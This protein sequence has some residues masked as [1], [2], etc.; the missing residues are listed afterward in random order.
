MDS[1][2]PSTV[3]SASQP[4]ESSSTAL[5][6]P[7]HSL[8]R[9]RPQEPT[10]L[11]EDTYVRAVS[12]IIE[13]DFFP[14]LQKMKVQNEYLN[15]LQGGE[16]AKAR[17]LGG[18]LQRMATE[19]PG[20]TPSGQTPRFGGNATPMPFDT[21]LSVSST[22]RSDVTHASSISA[23][24]AS[25]PNTKL[26]LDAFQTNYTSEDNA[27]FAG[28]IHKTNEEKKQRYAWVF[29]K[30][31]GKLLL[32]DEK[33]ET[34]CI[35]GMNKTIEGWKYKAKNSLMYYPEGAPETL[36]EQAAARGAPKAVSHASTRFTP[37][38]STE[39]LLK[40][41]EATAEQMRTQDVWREMAKATPALFPGMQH[42]SQ[43][44]VDGFAFVPSTPVLNPGSDVDPSD[45]MT[46]GVI[47]GTPLL[48]DS[49][50]DHS[51]ARSFTIPDTPKREQ[52]SHRLSEK[53][54]K[55]LRTRGSATTP[56]RNHG[57]KTPAPRDRSSI[58]ASPAF[59]RAASPF[60][61]SSALS[62]AAQHLLKQGKQT[63]FGISPLKGGDSQLRASY[64]MTPTKSS[65]LRTPSTGMRTPTQFT[66]DARRSTTKFIPELRIP[67]GGKPA[68]AT[69]DCSAATGSS[70]T[71]NL[72]QL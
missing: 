40:T 69:V 6:A 2:E 42:E 54:S 56:S 20:A 71:D 37:T 53:A 18:E 65:R 44:G 27:S 41:A 49:G 48:M 60:L 68:P 5:T 72:L 57:F 55:S 34:K 29:D 63:A 21:P 32:E 26:S 39:Q 19:N 14:N 50:A 43:P 52:L 70:I 66:P 10:V 12:A 13:R 30:E 3:A 15:A 51:G 28:I 45:L 16:Y 33:S 36:T 38:V 35:E 9:A 25:G 8:K 23:K 17:I 64:S 58:A 62:P 47:E 11:E 61:R 59:K 67:S 4:P 46:W 31:K 1:T 24:T 22:P 7:S